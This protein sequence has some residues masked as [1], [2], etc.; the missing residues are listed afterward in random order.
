MATPPHPPALPRGDA[1][2]SG[3]VKSI[4]RP[5]SKKTLS[6]R[7]HTLFEPRGGGAENGAS[8][9]NRAREIAEKGLFKEAVLLWE[10]AMRQG[11]VTPLHPATPLVWMINAGQHLKAARHFTTHEAILHYD[12]PALW[13]LTR[14]LLAV[15]CLTHD[16]DTRQLPPFN[17]PPWSQATALLSAMRALAHDDT[18]AVRT[19]LTAIDADSPFFPMR[20]IL[21]SLLV[22]AQEPARIRTLLEEIPDTSPFAP[23]AHLARMRGLAPRERV[24]AILDLP[25]EDKSLAARLCGATAPWIKLLVKLEKSRDPARLTALLIAN[26]DHLPR[27]ATRAACLE[28]LPD[29]PEE[30][31]PFEKRFG[32]LSELERER[33]FALHHERHGS[34]AKAR[35]YWRKCIPLLENAPDAPKQSLQIALILRHMAQLERRDPHPD[36]SKILQWLEKSLEHDPDHQPTWVE[37]LETRHRLGR[38]RL[39]FHRLADRAAH[40]FPEDEAILTLA[41]RAAMEKGSYKKASGVAR[42]IQKIN[43]GHDG[44]LSERLSAH[45]QHARKRIL[46]GRFTVA[47]RE[48]FRAERLSDEGSQPVGLLGAMLEFLAG[49][50]RRGEEMLDEGRRLASQKTLHA[51]KAFLEG[52]ALRLPGLMLDGFRRELIRCDALS[53]ERSELVIIAGLITRVWP[54]HPDAA[55]EVMTLLGGQLRAGLRL[56]FEAGELLMICEALALTRRHAML[57]QY[58]R[59]GE[60][61]FPDEPMFRYFRARGQCENQPWR[62]TDHDFQRLFDAEETLKESDP[63]AAARIRALLAIPSTHPPIDPLR[64]VPLSPARIPKLLESTLLRELRARLREELHGHTDAASLRQL[65]DRLLETLAPTEF[66]QRGPAV[67]GYLLD[68][69]LKLKPPRHEEANRQPAFPRQLELELSIE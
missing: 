42:R 57:T 9:L 14:E 47:R 30:R 2:P 21:E 22:S 36:T 26:A 59:V 16:N 39:T 35:S 56:P 55:G 44:I 58:A 25:H 52:T 10:R 43:P 51:V 48:L 23:L 69:A 64:G 28:L 20:R 66:G 11:G 34:P 6:K 62:L 61:Q 32:P 65:R 63:E 5:L 68:R 4:A 19:L 67:L 7:P 60:R 50:P 3:P 17:H 18:L 15:V 12:Q 45:L 29:C 49:D 53:A 31:G 40:R 37:I 46:E 8:T 38:D 27:A 13:S 33:L 54:T 24:K 41:L 1:D